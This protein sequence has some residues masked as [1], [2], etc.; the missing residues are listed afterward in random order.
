GNVDT[1]DV[2]LER[3][4]EFGDRLLDF[5]GGDVLPLPAEGVADAV[6]KI[7]I[8]VLVLPHQVTGAKPEVARL[9]NIVQD[10]LF[11]LGRG[12][13]A[14]EAGTGLGGV[15]ENPS[16]HLAGFIRSAFDAKPVRVA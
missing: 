5:G 9:E 8:A 4:V 16:D 12:G 3:A 11:G 1:K 6:D 14:F 10:L 13:V 2:G 7:E 15:L